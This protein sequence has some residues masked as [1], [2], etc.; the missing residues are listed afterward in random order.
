M[1]ATMILSPIEW[2]RLS[3][4]RAF[5]GDKR[6]TARAVAMAGRIMRNPSASLPT[7]M[8]SISAL[9]GSY[10]LLAEEDVTYEGLMSSHF[11]QPLQSA[12]SEHH[13]LMIQDTTEVDYTHHPTTTGL[14]PIGDGLVGLTPIP[15]VLV[16]PTKRWQRTGVAVA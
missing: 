16:K 4:G 2:A 3:F 1:N 10:R 6:R 14:G 15:K 12:Q 8:G 5:L 13:V 9:K 11:Q 7:Q